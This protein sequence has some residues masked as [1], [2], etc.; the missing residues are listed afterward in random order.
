[1]PLIPE[2]TIALT[3]IARLQ[4]RMTLNSCMVEKCSVAWMDKIARSRR[5]S[6]GESELNPLED[7]QPSYQLLEQAQVGPAR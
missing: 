5:K 7:A 1:M 3:V 6:C 4:E 2:Q